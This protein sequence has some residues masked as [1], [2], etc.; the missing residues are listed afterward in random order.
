MLTQNKPTYMAAIMWLSEF[1]NKHWI[2]YQTTRNIQ[3][4][5]KTKGK[6]FN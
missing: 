6:H 2:E 3:P 1:I 5:S 4:V